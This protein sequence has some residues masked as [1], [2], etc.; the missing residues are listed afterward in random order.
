MIC[1]E[2]LT[3]WTIFAPLG[4]DFET[5]LKSFGKSFQESLAFGQKDKN[6]IFSSTFEV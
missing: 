3:F 1:F 5:L 2:Y 6:D 4:F